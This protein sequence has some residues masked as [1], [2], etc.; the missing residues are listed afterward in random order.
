[1][2]HVWIVA[3][4]SAE[5]VIIKSLELNLT[6]CT[7]SNLLSKS[8]KVVASKK[9]LS[10]SEGIWEVSPLA[11]ERLALKCHSK[12]LKIKSNGKVKANSESIGEFECLKFIEQFVS[13]LFCSFLFFSDFLLV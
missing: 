5:L 6:L 11:D 12:Y 8:Q 4:L 2:A 1:M 9:E 7:Q 3:Q 13:L 10:E